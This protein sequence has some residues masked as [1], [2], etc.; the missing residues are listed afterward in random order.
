M[1]PPSGVARVLASVPQSGTYPRPRPRPRP[2]HHVANLASPPLRENVGISASVRVS[3]ITERQ[4]TTNRSVGT[5]V[6]ASKGARH[7]GAELMLAV[8]SKLTQDTPITSWLDLPCVK[9]GRAPRASYP[10]I[11]SSSHP[12]MSSSRCR[13]RIIDVP[14]IR[15]QDCSSA[16]SQ[17]PPSPLAAHR[18]IV[19]S[20]VRQ[21]APPLH[22]RAR[23]VAC[24]SKIPLLRTQARGVHLHEPRRN[25]CVL[26][27]K[28]SRPQRER[29]AGP[30]AAGLYRSCPS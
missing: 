9:L 29:D 25:R 1:R 10:L 7:A 15:R 2:R 28:R 30:P 16:P 8:S 23:G 20:H 4:P 6:A 13:C 22:N 12:L 26:R 18:L 21:T 5:E 17:H 11:L 3:Q 14:R 19:I 27:G 24:V